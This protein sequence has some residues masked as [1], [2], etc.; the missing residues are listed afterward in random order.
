MNTPNPPQGSWNPGPYDPS[1]PAPGWTASPNQ[2]PPWDPAASG[3]DMS[4]ALQQE[5]ART[6]EHAEIRERGVARWLLITTALAASVVVVGM[7]AWGWQELFWL[8]LLNDPNNY[9]ETP[10]GK[11]LVNDELIELLEQAGRSV[12]TAP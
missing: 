1:A 6:A 9:I 12:D 11:V 5:E 3:T 10:E 8:E 7:M 2:A 4:Q